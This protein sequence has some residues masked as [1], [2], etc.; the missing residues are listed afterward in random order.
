MT[1]K[2]KKPEIVQAADEP[3][4]AAEIIAQSI[5]NIAEAVRKL[6]AAGLKKRAILVL[7]RDS[8]GVGMSEIDRV[9]TAAA[10]LDKTYVTK[11]S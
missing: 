1:T 4:V 11:R 2:S 6:L 9:L 3:E 8:S 5:V 10:E 7:L